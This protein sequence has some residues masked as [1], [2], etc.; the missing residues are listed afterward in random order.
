[1]GYGYSVELKKRVLDYID[2]GHEKVAACKVFK[3]SRQ[4]VYDWLA[5]RV[6]L[7]KVSAPRRGARKRKLEREELIEHLRQ[8]S[9]AYLQEIGKHFG[10][11]GQSILDACRRWGITR[12]KNLILQRKKREG[13]KRLSQANRVHPPRK[14]RL[15][16]RKRD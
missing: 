8:H 7:G 11:S 9:D 12:K 15:P 6:K 10:T 1:M 16:R 5:Q 14:P 13:A 2:A 4:T 3:V